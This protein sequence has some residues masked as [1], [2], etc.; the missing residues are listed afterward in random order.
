MTISFGKES[1]I[2]IQDA[3]IMPIKNTILA[4]KQKF[5]QR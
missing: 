2:S 1:A 4:Y 5:S 3:Q